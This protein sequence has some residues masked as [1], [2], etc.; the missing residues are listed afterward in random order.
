MLQQFSSLDV[1]TLF[2]RLPRPV[3]QGVVYA[4]SA[5]NRVNR[6]G[7][8]YERQRS[9]LCN[10]ERWSRD[11]LLE[12]QRRQLADLLRE[13]KAGTD[14][15][16]EALANFSDSELARL[17][18][19]LEIQRLPLLSKSTLKSATKRFA[20]RLRKTYTRTS[21]SGSTGSPLVVEYDRRSVEQRFALLHRLR[22]AGGVGAFDRNVRLS[23]RQIAP[24]DA[25]RER[26]WLLNPFEHMLLVSTYHLRQP[27]LS[28]IVERVARFRPALIDGY[29]T[30]VEQLAEEAQRQGLK[31]P[32]LRMV[33]TTAETLS[34][35][36]RSG[37]ESA[38][39]VPVFDYYAASEGVPIIAQCERGTYHVW[40]DSG[41]FEFLRPD[42]SPAAAGEI[43]EIVVTS[44][45]QWKTPL[46]RYRT[47]DL[48]QLPA[49]GAPACPC[50]RSF[51][52]VAGVLGRVEDL[53][54]TR[55]GR[56]IGMFAY[57]TLK[58]VPGLAEAQIVQRDYDAF[59]VRLVPDGSRD[60]ADVQA[61]IQRIFAS[62]LGYEPSVS[63]EPVSKIERGPNG[64]FRTMVRA[65]Q[66]SDSPRISE[67]SC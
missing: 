20:N 42:G 52:T 54:V 10:S 40:E 53:V 30:A 17:A 19:E 64:K 24:S 66:L 2:L 55:D 28:R 25:E 63:F 60:L 48:A 50:G 57:R 13:A 14:Y 6:Y 32:S 41:I 33:I 47:G 36:T 18:K 65:F 62:T 58:H 15:Y 5:L 22:N 1:T 45:C 29:P 34:P 31:I 44:F 61:D 26:P 3:R 12:N 11:E 8:E 9:L 49:A 37:I 35:S 38:F 51:S 67:P 39:G 59:T 4:Q 56:R 27:H 23:G 7:A 43:G 46:I 21:T 16:A